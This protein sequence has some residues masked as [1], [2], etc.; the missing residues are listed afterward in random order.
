[1]ARDRHI[2]RGKLLP[3]YRVAQL[4]DP[5]SPFLEI[6]QLAAH[7]MYDGDAPSAG[8][9]AGIGRIEGVDCMVVANDAAVKGGTY[10]PMTVKSTCGRRRSPSRITFPVCIWSTRV[11]L[12]CRGRMRCSRTGSTLAGSS[13]TRH[14]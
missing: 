2:R 4:L 10:Y 6:G 14:T 7:G 5:D 8:V 12:S 1:M 9:I 13:T 11:G 3:R